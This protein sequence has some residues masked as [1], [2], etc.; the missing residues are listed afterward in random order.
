MTNDQK[1]FFRKAFQTYHDASVEL[2]QSEHAVRLFPLLNLKSL[3]LDGE[4]LDYLCDLVF[5]FSVFGSVNNYAILETSLIVLVHGIF[6][7]C[8]PESF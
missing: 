6:F 5:S 3:S 4:V 2:L 1:R 8:F 7:V